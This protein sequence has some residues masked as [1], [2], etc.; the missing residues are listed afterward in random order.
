MR[1]S[2]TSARPGSLVALFIALVPVCVMLIGSTLHATDNTITVNNT[3]DPAGTSGNGFCTLREAI[4]NANAKS[5]TSGGDCAAGTGNDAIVFSVSGTIPL[6][7]GLPAIQN[8]L[9]IDGSGQTVT[10]DG[11]SLCGVFVVNSTAAVELANLTIAHGNAQY[12]GGVENSDGTLTV[13]NVTFNANSAQWGGAIFNDI[14][15]TLTVTGSTFSGNQAQSSAGAIYNAG[16]S[17]TQTITNSTFTGNWAQDDGGAIFGDVFSILTVT[18][19]TFSGNAAVQGGNIFSNTGPPHG[20]SLAVTN[21]ILASGSHN[22][23]GTVTDGGYNIS[24]DATCDFSGTSVNRTHPLLDP[25][26]LQNNGGPTE[27]IALCSG[28]PAIAAVPQAHCPDGDQRGDP[29]PSPGQTACDIGAFEG[30]IACPTP[31]ATRTP[32]ATPTRTPTP[33]PTLTPT[34]TPSPTGQISLTPQ[35]VNFGKV[36]VKTSARKTIQVKNSAKGVLDV[37]V[38]NN[39]TPPFGERG[40]GSFRLHKGKSHSVVVTF[41]PS[42]TGGTA[43]QTL[44]V[45]SND[46][47][48]NNLN[49]LVVGAGKE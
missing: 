8:S 10:I 25:A 13:T 15:G 49:V 24:D 31:T 34:A 48:H 28:S 17:G 29:R 12:G 11:G 4:N 38:E 33:T 41:K 43:P 42:A 23:S 32:T 47:K 36:K 2:R 21:S 45:H 1:I 7:S 14:F 26:G 35:T 5:D 40:S 9:T 6:G 46:P 19:A 30:S 18:N 16:S 3:T 27:T 37:T 20:G 22:C 44:L 39:L